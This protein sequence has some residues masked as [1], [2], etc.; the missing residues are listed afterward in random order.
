MRPSPWS[1]QVPSLRVPGCAC[2]R[3]GGLFRAL[4]PARC[5]GRPANPTSSQ[6]LGAAWRGRRPGRRFPKHHKVVLCSPAD[7]Q[8]APV[9]VALRR[10]GIGRACETPPRFRARPHSPGAATPPPRPPCA[11]A[12]PPGARSWRC[13]RPAPRPVRSQVRVRLERRQHS[14][15]V[16]EA[17]LVTAMPAA[18]TPLPDQQAA[19]A[20]TTTRT[21]LPASV[22]RP[23]DRLQPRQKSWSAGVAFSV[24]RGSPSIIQHRETGAPTSCSWLFI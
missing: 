24:P 16:N 22:H 3:G 7:P 17:S 23:A 15:V 8:A 10:T 2:Q 14:P 18:R 11:C 6:F 19:A 9:G 4:W 1:H 21:A 20:R 5:W 13:T 12:P